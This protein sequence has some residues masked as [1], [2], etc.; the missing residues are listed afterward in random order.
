MGAK[1]GDTSCWVFLCSGRVILARRGVWA[2]WIASLGLPEG[3]D[4]CCPPGSWVHAASPEPQ[5]RMAPPSRVMKKRRCVMISTP[6]ARA[7]LLIAQ[8]DRRSG[9]AGDALFLARASEQD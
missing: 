7:P 2:S 9:P 8:R 5:T 3:G 1:I 6:R 4:D